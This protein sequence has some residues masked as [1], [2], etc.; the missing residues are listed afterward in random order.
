VKYLVWG[1]QM[2]RTTQSWPLA[3]R[4]TATGAALATTCLLQLPIERE[5]PGEPFLPF[6]LVVIAATLA[7]G[8]NI[9]FVSAALSAFLSILFFEPGGTLALHHAADLIKIE[10][11]AILAACS[12]V[13]LHVSEMG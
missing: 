10:L 2:L 4:L 6:F 9:G 7:F 8:A 12:V 13:A 11:Y 1:V 3:I 5:V